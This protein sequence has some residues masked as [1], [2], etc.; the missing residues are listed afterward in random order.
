MWLDKVCTNKLPETMF[1]RK[2]KV[3]IKK[4][5]SL[6]VNI[7]EDLYLDIQHYCD[8]SGYS[9]TQIVMN[10]LKTLLAVKEEERVLKAENPNRRV[11]SRVIMETIPKED[12]EPRMAAV[13]MY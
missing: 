13:L 3:S 7:P 5:R 1:E 6:N 9:K 4:K 10:A 8:E 12:E 2:T 11:K